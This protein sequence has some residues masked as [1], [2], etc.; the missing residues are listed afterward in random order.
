[1]GGREEGRKRE[2]RGEEGK[3]GKEKKERKKGGREE[4]K[5]EEKGDSSAADAGK[6]VQTEATRSAISRQ[7]VPAMSPMMVMTAES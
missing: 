3:R 5:R 7:S 4:G 6:R 1:G 2:R